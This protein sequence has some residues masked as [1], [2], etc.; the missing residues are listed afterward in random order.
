MAYPARTSSDD[1]SS[2]LDTDGLLL[3]TF[4]MTADELGPSTA[5]NIYPT[6]GIDDVGAH[7]APP[8]DNWLETDV[9]DLSTLDFDMDSLSWNPSIDPGMG[10]L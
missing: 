10:L 4:N 5:W 7:L 9:D 1:F 3:H 6:A 8:P 2:A